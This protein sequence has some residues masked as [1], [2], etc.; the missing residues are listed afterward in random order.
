MKPTLLTGLIWVATLTSGCASPSEEVLPAYGPPPE[1]AEPLYVVGV[2][3]LH[4]PLRLRETFGPLVDLLSNRIPN[5]EFRLEAS[6]D[7]AAYEEK[8]FGQTLDFALPNP[9]QTVRA[10]ERGYHV[11]GKMAD[12]H[13]F[14]GIILVRRDR[15]VREVRDLAGQAVSF[16]APTA[17]AATL[18]PRLYL[19]RAGLRVE[20]EIES[21]YVGSQESSI[22]SV[23]HGDTAAG[24][25]GPP[26]WRALSKERPEVAE[27]L[28]VAWETDPL[29]NNSWMVRDTVP[30]AVT[31]AV[32][33]QLF[34]LHEHEE[35]RAILAR[36]ELSSFVPADDDTY[37]PVRAFLDAYST[38][39]GPL[40]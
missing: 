35:G 12:D 28:R 34:T 29:P 25:T 18:M 26:P 37:A 1:R 22:L 8:L 38:E 20:T 3:P 7:Y 15:D 11:F 27:A 9:Y 40:P 30:E 16:P 39:V 19:Q 14:R 23:F 13:N 36:M 5:A 6:R 21:R 10:Q 17:L 32:A 33:E 24:A 2:H 31:R 4:N